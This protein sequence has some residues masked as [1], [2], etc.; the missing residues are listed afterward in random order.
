MF[1]PTSPKLRLDGS[2]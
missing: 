1:D 2:P